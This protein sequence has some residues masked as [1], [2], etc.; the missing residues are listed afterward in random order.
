[1]SK[2]VL[3]MGWI[4]LAALLSLSLAIFPACGGGEE[5]EE[6][7]GIPYKNDGDFVQETIGEISS[8]D[9]AWAY[10]TAGGEQIQY[11]YET[12]IFFDG[13]ST[14]TFVN[15]LADS[16]NVV[17]STTI[18][19]HIRP[20]VKF[21]NGDPLTPADVEYSIERVMIQDR[22]GGPAWML[23]IPLL[24]YPRTRSAGAIRPGIF[25]KIANA[26]EVD[27]EYVVINM[28][29]AT[30]YSPTVLLQILCSSW[31]AIV[32]KQWCIANGEW[33]GTADLGTGNSTAWYKYNNPTK[34]SSYL[35]N[36]TMGTGPWQ[37]D[38]WAPGDYIRLLKNDNWWKGTPPFNMVLTKKVDEWTSRK[39]SLLNGDADFVYVPRNYIGE[40]AGVADLN[41]IKD[42]PDIA[43]ESLFINFN[44]DTN[45]EYIG[46]GALDGNGIPTDFFTDINVRKGFAYCF[47][48][49]TYINDAMQGEAEQR[50]SPMVKGLTYYS[51]TQDSKLY[52]YDP[53][54]AE[55]YLRAAWNGTLW[56]TG[57]RF[58]L[59][60]NIGND[61][62]RIASEIL[63]D[64]LMALNPNFR[65]DVLAIEW[66]VFLDKMS[67]SPCDMPIWVV[68]WQVDY[69]DADDFI[70]PYMATYG[71]FSYFQGYGTAE[72]DALIEQARYSTDPTERQALYNQLAG[73]F[74]ED[75]PT[76]MTAQP[77]GRRFFTKYIDGFYF[78]PCIFGQ[79]GPLWAMSK[80]QS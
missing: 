33:D 76:I 30:A 29:P 9:P 48:W 57:F 21:S 52:S 58:T 24:G 37:L 5:E 8:L 35:Y 17:D 71:D 7:V 79:A 62:R 2:R 64:N 34:Q 63:A 13:T 41:P 68:G 51:P 6:E 16:Y 12:L 25:D 46:S 70:S 43:I 75:C 20:G 38:V 49:D 47:N 69:P 50:G 73:I 39:L 53:V 26:V 72:I 19:F 36:H 74:Y 77:L 32:D 23:N 65:V 4:V 61:P 78:N 1:M 60:Y 42:L 67:T 14:A 11:M 15:V 27:G 45:S 59:C 66:D 31:G 54:Q 10:D 56:D 80:S 3:K 44:I 28:N 22:G 40:L 55:Q 18:R